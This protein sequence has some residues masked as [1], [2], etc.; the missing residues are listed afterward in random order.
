MRRHLV[1]LLIVSLA[2]S[3][4]SAAGAQEGAA[5]A[6]AKAS[7]PTPDCTK[8]GGGGANRLRG[9]GGPDILCAKGGRDRLFGKDGED[10]LIGGKGRDRV[11]GGAKNDLLIGGRGHDKLNGGRGVDV[12]IKPKGDTLRSIEIKL[13]GARAKAHFLKQRARKSADVFTIREVVDIVSVDLFELWS[14]V[15]NNFTDVG[16]YFYYQPGVDIACGTDTLPAENMV[17]CGGGLQNGSVANGGYKWILIDEAYGNKL[18]NGGTLQDGSTIPAYGD[19]AAAYAIAHEYGHHVQ[20]VLGYSDSLDQYIVDNCQALP[21]E[22]KRQVTIRRE[23][24]ADCD[25]GIYLRWAWYKGIAS[26]ADFQEALNVAYYIG[27]LDGGLGDHGDALQR[28]RWVYAGFQD[29]DIGVCES[30][31]GSLNP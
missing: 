2:T 20:E 13:G 28:F 15:Y 25:G 16:G 12:A 31:F 23:L 4:S 17:Y 5:Q 24:N 14:K 18:I 11:K 7:I 8:S 19:G 3:M 10:Q 21:C 26:E 1:A 29:Y 9:T 22:V 27:S 6:R 30:V